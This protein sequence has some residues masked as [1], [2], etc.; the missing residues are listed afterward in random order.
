[1]MLLGD[2]QAVREALGSKWLGV[3]LVAKHYFH[4]AIPVEGII[5]YGVN[6]RS[7]DACQ[8]IGSLGRVSCLGKDVC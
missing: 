7:E 6:E 3:R 2:G 4:L 8:N 1:M 5:M